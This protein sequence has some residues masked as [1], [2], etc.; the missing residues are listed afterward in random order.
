[1]KIPNFGYI[2]AYKKNVYKKKYYYISLY[3]TP[4]SDLGDAGSLSGAILSF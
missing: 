1:M 2:L 4:T 3:N